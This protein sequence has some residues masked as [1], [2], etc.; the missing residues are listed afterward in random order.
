[1]VEKP[2]SVTRAVRIERVSKNLGKRGEGKKRQIKSDVRIN[3]Y[4][5]SK[6]DLLRVPD[7]ARNNKKKE[8]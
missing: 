2:I 4:V 8:K 7:C 1:M 5:K 3:G 6:G